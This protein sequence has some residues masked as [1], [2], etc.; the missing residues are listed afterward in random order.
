M[1]AAQDVPIAGAIIVST[2]QPV[3]LEDAAK[4]IA[5]FE[6]LTVPVLGIV[7]NMSYFITPDTGRRVEIFGH[8]G[9]EAAAEDHAI[10]FLGAI[11]LA[12]E[13]RAGGDEG[14]PVVEF[15]PDGP[16]AAAFR[17]I[18][19]R[20]AAKAAVLDRMAPPAAPAHTPAAHMPVS[21][22]P[23]PAASTPSERSII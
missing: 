2:P 8:G 5:M 21:G 7:E 23:A 1:S 12:T 17:D 4:A 6:K 19:E 13:I 22:R 18:A 9:A 11:P 10:D 3:A 16:I 20:V 14:R 15:L